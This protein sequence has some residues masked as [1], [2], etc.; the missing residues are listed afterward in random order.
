MTGLF[1]D[2]L[3]SNT[4][5][6]P[7]AVTES[8]ELPTTENPTGLGLADSQP[9]AAPPPTEEAG[10]DFGGLAKKVGRAG[11]GFAAGLKGGLS[12][13]RAEALFDKGGGGTTDKRALGISQLMDAT[14]KVLDVANKLT[15]ENRD[16]QLEI[17]AKAISDI[18]PGAGDS[19]KAIAAQPDKGDLIRE[20]LPNSE[21]I[22]RSLEIDP[23]GSDA[24]KL[25]ATKEGIELIQKEGEIKQVSSINRKLRGQLLGLQNI[26]SPDR[27]EQIK[28]DGVVSES[29]IRE[30][31]QIA[32]SHKDPEIQALALSD[33][34][35][36]T[37]GNNKKVTFASVGILTGEKDQEVLAAKAKGGLKDG[38]TLAV[39]DGE[40]TV[41]L[42]F[43]PSGNV[44][45][46]KDGSKAIDRGNGFFEIGRGK[47]ERISSFFGLGPDGKVGRITKKGDKTTIDTN[48]QP[49]PKE[50]DPIK[51]LIAQKIK[52]AGIKKPEGIADEVLSRFLEDRE[53]NPDLKGTEIKKTKRGFEVF[54]GNKSIGFFD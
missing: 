8:L 23:T 48:F 24:A 13:L 14:N 51:E 10:F 33:T 37:A 12:A 42:I 35:L 26:L 36:T 30:A 28:K 25:M 3:L 40:E 53:T 46:N 47:S 4:A 17:G 43:S 41:N 50:T 11:F 49:V 22:A 44:P 1:Q 39:K 2:E 52:E 21:I 34:E 27:F 18:L 31:N 45:L 16:K 54:K 32:R 29:E 6:D 9:V 15:G 5:Q 20:H 38:A 19:L 7:S